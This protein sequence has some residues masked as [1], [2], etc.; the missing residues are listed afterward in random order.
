M[1]ATA[2]TTAEAQPARAIAKELT[3]Q[4]IMQDRYGDAGVLRLRE[5][6]R[7]VAAEGDVLVRVR[8]AAVSAG[9]GHLLTGRPF[10]ARLGIGLRRPKAAVAG[11]D[12]AGTVEAVGEGVTDLEAGADVF[13]WGTGA[14]AEFV[15]VPASQ[16]LTKPSG[17]SFEHAATLPMSGMTALQAVRDIGMVRAG[18]R[19]LITGPTGGVG[20]FAVQIAKAYGAH[21]TAVTSTSKLEVATSIGADAVI[22]Y[23]RDDFTRSGEQWDVIIDIAGRRGLRDLRRALAPT[24]RLVLVGGEGGDR[25]LGGF[26]RHIRAVLWSPFVRHDLRALVSGERR[27]DLA[28]LLRLVEDGRVTPVIDRVYPLAETAEAYRHLAAGEARGK[29][30]VTMN[31][32]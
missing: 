19:V 29:T 15:S 10:V 13:G 4:A 6:P 22:D 30:V 12:L 20:S 27:E 7:P 23:T 17:V 18:Q 32:G 9:D 2:A 24:G 3:M 28:D 31:G 11:L 25:W 14:F 8:A 5:I 26:D 1:T 16:L 21:V